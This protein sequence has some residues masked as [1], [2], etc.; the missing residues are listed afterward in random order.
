M[1]LSLATQPPPPPQKKRKGDFKD[2]IV[3][4]GDQTIDIALK[5]PQSYPYQVNGVHNPKEQKK[6]QRKDKKE[7][8]REKIKETRKQIYHEKF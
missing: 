2:N 3:A 7:V 6:E 1:P 5:K 4:L 8:T